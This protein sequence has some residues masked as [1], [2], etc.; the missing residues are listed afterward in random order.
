MTS[1][2]KILIVIAAC[3][4]TFLLFWIYRSLA[5]RD[6]AQAKI[7]H[8]QRSN[9][10]CSVA[11]SVERRLPANLVRLLRIKEIEHRYWDEQEDLR[12]ALVASGYLTNVS[13]TVTN[14]L[15]RRTQLAARLT[16]AFKGVE[17]EWQ[18]YVRSN[19]EVVV[20][21]RPEHV[22]LCRQALEE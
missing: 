19:Q 5:P 7:E 17:N 11:F 2:R 9:R 14:P 15:S 16:K 4:S 22:A 20:T 21:C 8:W 3:A 18:F 1:K 10:R 13:I 6:D 12:E